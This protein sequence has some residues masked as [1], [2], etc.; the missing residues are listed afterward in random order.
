MKAFGRRLRKADIN[1]FVYGRFSTSKAKFDSAKLEALITDKKPV[2]QSLPKNTKWLLVHGLYVLNPSAASGA[3]SED[4][5]GV[6]VSCFGDMGV[7]LPSLS[8]ETGDFND[9]VAQYK[10]VRDWIAK[11][12]DKARLI[13]ANDFESW[14]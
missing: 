8:K 14:R 4:N 7:V 2:L 9:C 3:P 13:V 6:Q 11:N 10:V 12:G 1:D 5:V